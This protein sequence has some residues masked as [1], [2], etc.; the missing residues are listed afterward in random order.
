MQFRPAITFISNTILIAWQ[1]SRAE[2]GTDIYMQRLNQAGE[3]RWTNDARVTDVEGSPIRERY[4]P[5]IASNAN[6]DIIVAWADTRTGARFSLWGQRYIL[7]SIL[8]SNPPTAAKNTLLSGRSSNVSFYKTHVTMGADGSAYAVWE[9]LGAGVLMQRIGLLGQRLW[10]TDTKVSPTTLGALYPT[11]AIAPDSASLPLVVWTKSN[12]SN[13]GIY[14]NKFRPTGEA[15]W[16]SPARISQTTGKRFVPFGEVSSQIVPTLGAPIK[17]AVLTADCEP[18]TKCGGITFE[19][20]SNNGLTW[21]RVVPGV[22]IV[23]PSP[24]GDALRW[25]AAIQADASYITSTL[26][27]SLQINYTNANP[28]TFMFYVAGDND[29]HRRLWSAVDA[30]RSSIRQQNLLLPNLNVVV[31]F[32]GS[33]KEDMRLE[34]I[35]SNLDQ[36]ESI[37]LLVEKNRN[38]GDP[39]TL[40]WFVQ[41]VRTYYPGEHYYLAIADH[42]LGTLGVAFDTQGNPVQWQARTTAHLSPTLLSQAL[43]TATL[44]G[45]QKIDVIQFDTCLTGLFEMAYEIRKYGHYMVASE[46]LI[47]SAF[48][49][50]KYV[51]AVPLTET[52]SPSEVAIRVADAYADSQALRDMPLTIST[53]DLA[54]VTTTNSTLL[55]FADVLINELS[56]NTNFTKV[57][58]DVRTSTQKFPE[59]PRRFMSN[60]DEYIDLYDFARRLSERPDIRQPVQQAARALMQSL[61]NTLPSGNSE[62]LIIH[63]RQKSG[64]SE[65]NASAYW[66]YSNSHGIALYFPIRPVNLITC[67]VFSSY[68]GITNTSSLFEFSLNNRWPNFLLAFYTSAGLIRSDAKCA[69]QPPPVIDDGA[70]P[71]PV[72]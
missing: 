12:G 31:L 41:W 44:G 14:A 15:A 49:F 51:N 59:N 16:I 8:N 17:R 54:Q 10:L 64:Y 66:N 69:Y 67:S 63:H 55:V 38:M 45:T 62:P 40:A 32:D 70:R 26:V 60:E 27:N 18:D 19:L 47:W 6:G 36:P 39:A 1:D 13:G 9:D 56:T 48:P 25:R 35:H 28:W 7:A 20:T 71:T 30:L 23:F 65:L 5:S 22:P 52:V 37:P 46:G 24:N 50:A 57:I 43:F 2:D 58:S 68:V 53:I 29:L 61:R 3:G 33:G 11:V 72:P 42:G 4:A 21:T 34:V